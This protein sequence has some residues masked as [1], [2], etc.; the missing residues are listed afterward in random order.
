MRYP[1]VTIPI[2]PYLL[3]PTG[4]DLTSFAFSPFLALIWIPLSWLFSP[5]A[6]YNLVMLITIVLC[7]ISMEQLVRYLTGDCRAACVSAIAFGFAPCLAAQ[8]AAHLTWPCW[9]GS[10]GVHSC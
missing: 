2:T 6:A 4:F 1:Q 7:C 9:P 5:I 10:R 8:R 3:Y